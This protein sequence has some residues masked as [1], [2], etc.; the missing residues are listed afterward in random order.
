VPWV[1]LAFLS[2][3]LGVF[4]LFCHS[5]LLITAV[6][7]CKMRAETKTVCQMNLPGDSSAT[8]S[9][10]C[11]S[12]L[13]ACFHLRDLGLSLLCTWHCYCYV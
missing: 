13:Q 3:K 10:A 8:G 1:L 6:L 4:L 7:N 11:V 12:P 5:V 2:H 9:Y